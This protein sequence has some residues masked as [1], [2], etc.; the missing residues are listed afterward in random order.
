MLYRIAFE[1]PTWTIE[2]SKNAMAGLL[3]D[4]I[5]K[6][7]NEIIYYANERVFM[8]PKQLEGL[9]GVSVSN[10]HGNSNWF[11]IHQHML[12]DIKLILAEQAL[13]T[14]D[15]EDRLQRIG[16]YIQNLNDMLDEST[17]IAAD[18]EVTTDGTIGL[19]KP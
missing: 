16:H 11:A 1:Y 14:H 13:N 12:K 18:I 10:I 17:R 3:F 2:G 8:M 15:I 6:A 19:L 5:G 7:G 9:T 4:L